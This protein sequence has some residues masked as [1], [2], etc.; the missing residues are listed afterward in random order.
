MFIVALIFGAIQVLLSWQLMVSTDK[1][2]SKKTFLFIAIKFLVYG[3]GIGT[4][5]LNHVWE[6]GSAIAGFAV[7]APIAAITLFVYNTIFK[8]R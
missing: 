3:I 1:K 6:L 4:L 7:G 8:K 2:M 5:V